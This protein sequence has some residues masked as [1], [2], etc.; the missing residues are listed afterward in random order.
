M[1]TNSKALL[2]DIPRCIGCRTCERTCKQTHNLPEEVEPELSATALTVVQERRDRFVRK[3]CLHCQDPACA[4]ACP[5]GALEKTVA[6]PVV[7]KA[8][9]CI[10]C[11][12]CMLAC[13]FSVPRY[14]W[15]KLA[16]YVKKCDLCAERVAAG[17]L[18]ACVE[19]CPVGAVVFGDR[20]EMLAEARRRIR[21]NPAYIQRVYGE[22]E[23]GGTSVLFLS[24]VP[25]EQL[26]FV[27]LPGQQPMPVLTAS[28]LQDVPTVVTMGCA[29]LAALYWI[30]QRREEVA[31][32]EAEEENPDYLFPAPRFAG[33]DE[34]RS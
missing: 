9:R 27:A 7:Y 15:T 2:V 5:V 26:G 3:L 20:D 31:R 16:P 4:S 8:D 18:P 10:G 32:A 25:F 29:I 30:T 24:D 17:G 22:V 19:A 34:E 23:V 1:R 21:E 11:R 14:E 13:P 33:E 28:A 6:G 12:Y